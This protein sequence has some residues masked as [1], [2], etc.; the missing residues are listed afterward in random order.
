VKPS[1]PRVPTGTGWPGARAPHARLADA[2]HE[3]TEWEVDAAYH[4]GFQDGEA[5]AHT[6]IERG[7]TDLLGGPDARN[8]KHAVEIHERELARKQRRE[9]ADR[10]ELVP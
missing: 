1:A 4:R 10:G 6:D 2:W 5:Y 3:Q 8:Y 9:A 7:L